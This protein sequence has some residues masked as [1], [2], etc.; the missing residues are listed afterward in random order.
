M[1]L[2]G[3]QIKWGFGRHMYYLLQTQQSRE[4]LIQSNKISTILQ[5]LT[6][7][8]LLFIKCS[9]G[10][11]MLRAFGS[12]RSCRWTVWSIMSFVFLATMIN[13][14]TLLAQCRPLHKVW[15]S[16]APGKCWSPDVVIRVGY[17]NGG[18]FVDG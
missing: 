3:W 8:D 13:A 6:V 7:F 14:I 2:A 5:F 4:Q 18:M 10:F 12:K 9:I 16:A 15:N 11:F 1:I 17:Y